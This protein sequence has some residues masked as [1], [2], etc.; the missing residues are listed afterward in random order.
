MHA[1][2]VVPIFMSA[3]AAVMPAVA[4]ALASVAAILFKPRELLRV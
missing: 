1:L 4:G 3:G 2:G